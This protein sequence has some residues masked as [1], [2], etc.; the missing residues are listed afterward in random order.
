M[1]KLCISMYFT[2]RC[3][4]C[5]VFMLVA[6]TCIF[7]KDHVEKAAHQALT[8]FC[9]RHLPVLGDTATALPPIQNEGKAV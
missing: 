4:P 5:I 7:A 8:E 1:G 2:T 3:T 6:H 9:E